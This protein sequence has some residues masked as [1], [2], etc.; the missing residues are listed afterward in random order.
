MIRCKY[1][2]PI[3]SLINSFG[4]DGVLEIPTINEDYELTTELKNILDKLTVE[5][6]LK[7]SELN[8]EGL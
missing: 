5:L 4:L 7:K 2:P 6:P 1:S 3:Y 8:N